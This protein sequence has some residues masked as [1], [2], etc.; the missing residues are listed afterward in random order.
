MEV[1]ETKITQYGHQGGKHIMA[2]VL[3]I[4]G[5]PRVSKLWIN[6]TIY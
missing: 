5:N 1:L 6:D 3:N 4:S 2:G